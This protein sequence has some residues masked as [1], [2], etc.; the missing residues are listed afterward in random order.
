MNFLHQIFI[1]KFHIV[2]IWKKFKFFL[3]IHETSK[4]KL[5]LTF[6]SSLFFTALI[7]RIR[8]ACEIWRVSLKCLL[9]LLLWSLFFHRNFDL[10]WYTNWSKVRRKTF[11]KFLWY[12]KKWAGFK[13]FSL[14][15]FDRIVRGS[16][17][18]IERRF[19]CYQTRKSLRFSMEKLRIGRVKIKRLRCKKVRRQI[20]EYFFGKCQ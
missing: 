15:I 14:L 9:L 6:F 12:E 18:A 3:K 16:L 10:I 11:D 7:E 5:V 2:V 8:F 4:I 13:V 20:F 17:N 1:Q 19:G